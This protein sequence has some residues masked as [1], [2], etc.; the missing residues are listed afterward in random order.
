M[1]PAAYYLFVVAVSLAVTASAQTSNP[2]FEA[3]SIKRAAPGFVPPSPRPPNPKA[4]EGVSLQQTRRM[5]QT[6]LHARFG[7]TV[8]N[9]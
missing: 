2:A 6:L 3:A 9:A 7:L 8:R 4:P 1:K 5:V